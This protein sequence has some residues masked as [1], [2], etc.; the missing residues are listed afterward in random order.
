MKRLYERIE[1][2]RNL[3]DDWDSYGARAPR[4]VAIV[5]THRFVVAFIRCADQDRVQ[6]IPTNDGGVALCGI[7]GNGDEL[8][9]EFR[10][11]GTWKLDDCVSVPLVKK[12]AGDAEA[13]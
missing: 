10:P 8:S 13:T 2:L 11:D 4:W 5:S 7:D 6:V 9:I 1:D 3:K 12:E